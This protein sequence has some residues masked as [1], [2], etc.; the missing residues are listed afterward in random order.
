MMML[1][2]IITIMEMEGED[3]L[4]ML[5]YTQRNEGTILLQ[6]QR[7]PLPNTRR[8]MQNCKSTPK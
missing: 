2:M 1:M 3:G 5:L 7:H 8:W 6:M 4:V